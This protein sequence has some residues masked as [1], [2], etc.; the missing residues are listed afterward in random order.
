VRRGDSLSEHWFWSACDWTRSSSRI[1]SVQ[2]ALLSDEFN[3][4]DRARRINDFDS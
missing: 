3:G 4:S 2:T 1:G